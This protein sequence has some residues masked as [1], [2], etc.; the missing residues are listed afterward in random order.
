MKRRFGKIGALPLLCA[1]GAAVA[2]GAASSAAPESRPLARDSECLARTRAL[3]GRGFREYESAHYVVLSDAGG[4][5]SRAQ[6]QRL[7]QA[8]RQFQR[9]VERLGLAADPLRHK[10]VGVLFDDRRAYAEFARTHDRVSAA[11]NNGY[12]APASDRLVLFN[13]EAEKGADEFAGQRTIAATVHEAIH[14]LHYHTNLQNRHVQYPLW[15]C[16]GLATCFETSDPAAPFGPGVEFAP[17]RERFDRLLRGDDLLPL[18][19][20]VQLDRMPDGKR[21][22]VF[23]V[24]NQS[25]A[26]LTWLA[27]ERPAQ[28]REYLHRMREHAPGRPSPAA[29]LDAFTACFGDPDEVERAWLADELARAG[30]AS[31]AQ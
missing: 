9:Y 15:S 30:M 20:L 16:E 26:L 7:E 11:W 6:L 17:R 3:V 10:L 22:T 18:R 8:R 14:Q 28:L 24:Y 25:Y 27:L 12:Y 21:E 13:G 23:T 31:A 2:S 19:V 1:A 5:F 4:A 29:H